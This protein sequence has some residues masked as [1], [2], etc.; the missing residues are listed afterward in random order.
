MS[1]PIFVTQPYLPP[2][3]EYLPYLEKIWQNKIL[4]NAG[5]FHEELED[6]LCKH[7]GVKH[8]SLFGNGTIALMV[9]I[10]ALE[11]EGEIITTPYSFVASSHAIAWN[12]IRPVFV[13]VDPLTCN[14]NPRKIEEAISSRTTAIL[15]VHVYGNPCDV[16]QI[17][18][19]A[20][21]HGIKVI[22]DAAHAMG[23]KLDNNSVLN[24][25]DLSVLSFHATKVF[26]TFE[27][28]AIVCQSAEMKKKI[29]DLKN[30]GFQS[31]ISVQGIG[32]NGKMNEMQASMGLIQLKYL[33]KVIYQRGLIAQD[34]R[35]AL[36]NIPGLRYQYENQGLEQNYSYFPIFIS[37]KEFGKS[38]DDL[39]EY[40]KQNSIYTRRY[41][42]PL[43]PEFNEYHKNTIRVEEG[44]PV[45]YQLSREVI[46]LPI[47]PDLNQEDVS[48]ISRMIRSYR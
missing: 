16:T 14:I 11:L 19:I 35:K 12:H 21:E 45:A 31:E 43:I 2:I 44:Y 41:F 40:L 46:C 38:R 3:E 37:E 48:R 25:G 4:T 7:L 10:K 30:F 15:P 18:S 39:F 28:G 6:A 26:N 17:D 42:Y 34:Y 36:S 8:I 47:Y 22:Y 9:A 20:R 24:F 13:D 29:D 23:V 27:G 33:K 5:P 32:I 1:K